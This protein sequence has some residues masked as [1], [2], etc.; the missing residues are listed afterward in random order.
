MIEWAVDQGTPARV[1]DPGGGSGRF[2]LAAARRWPKAELVATDV[3]PLATLMARANLAAAGF[4]S[5]SRVLLEDY[6]SLALDRIDGPTLYLG[7][8][9]YVRHHQIEGKWKQWLMTTAR[10]R[11][12]SASGL[13]GLHVHF[14]LATAAHGQPGDTGVF[15]TSAEWLDVNYGSLVREL[16]LHGLGGVGVYL[17]EPHAARFADA[18]TTGAIT[19]F[20]LGTRAKSIRLR[21]VKTVDGLGRLD[22]GRPVTR[23]RLAEARRWSPLTHVSTKVPE[24]HVELGELCRVHRGTVTGSNRVWIAGAGEIELPEDLLT[25]SV[26]KAREL[27][28]AGPTLRNAESLRRVID[29]PIDLDVLDAE[30]RRV[31]DEF[32]K[33]AKRLGA[34]DGYVAR[35]RRAW[36]SVGLRKPAPILTTYMARR[37]PAFVRNLANARH[38]NIAHG[39]Y[40]RQPM[41]QADLDRLAS[42]LRASVTLAQGRT[43]AGGLTKFEPREMERLTVPVP[44]T[45]ADG[46]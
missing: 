4:A 17:L 7:N 27:F 10:S 35:N 5:R 44:F 46:N 24:G 30:A 37:L 9:P 29:L 22:G 43:Y 41:T 2:T 34:A 1:V 33:V 15:V 19:C 38:V 36:W 3:D 11:G 40:P 28:A 39:V 13:S 42:S 20:R 18:A 23:E 16:L 14:F 32:L 21:R 25:P 26:T 31:V 45:A 12:L 6:R 8:P